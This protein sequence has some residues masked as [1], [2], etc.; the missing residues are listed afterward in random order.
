MFSKKKKFMVLDVEGNSAVK[1]YNVGYVIADNDGKIYVKRSIALP[2]CIWENLANAIRYGICADMHKKNVE[3]ILSDFNKPK[4][5]R[6]YLAIGITQF[7]EMFSHDVTKY[8]VKELFAYNVTFDNSALYRLFGERFNELDLQ[9]KDIISGLL[10]TRLKNQRYLDFCCENGYITEKGNFQYKAEYTYQF[11][12]GDTNFIEEHTALSDVLIEL[13]LL[14][15]A[16]RAHKK[17]DWNV[18]QAWQEL[19]NYAESIGYIKKVVDKPL[20]M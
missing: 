19:S 14:L 13:E 16:K 2:D 5:K 9:P 1:P 17:I 20:E 4:R 10:D 15:W 18:R 11:Y 8:K 6:K 3:E 7:W 12:T